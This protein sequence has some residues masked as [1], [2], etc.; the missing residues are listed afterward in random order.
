MNIPGCHD[1][2]VPV[3]PTNEQIVSQLKEKI[4]GGSYNIGQL[5]VPQSYEKIVLINDKLVQETT[6]T[7]G[8]KMDLLDVRKNMLKKTG[9]RHEIKN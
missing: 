3:E 5:I 1:V 2:S 4:V 6:T 9:K 7:E 8:R